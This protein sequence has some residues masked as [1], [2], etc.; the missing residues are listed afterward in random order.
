MT[1]CVRLHEETIEG[2]DATTPV[3]TSGN[4]SRFI[5]AIPDQFANKTV[6]IGFRH[7][8][9]TDMFY[10]NLDDVAI[11]DTNP[12]AASPRT[13]LSAVPVRSVSSKAKSVYSDDSK[14][15][16]SKSLTRK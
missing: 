15:V 7:F 9:C 10:L 16:N 1:S 6:Y 8:G 3:E 14:N 2:G 12:K 4:F 11:F 5:I 13:I